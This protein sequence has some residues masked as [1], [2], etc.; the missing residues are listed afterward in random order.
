MSNI[1]LNF[2]FRTL[3][4]TTLGKPQIND[5]THS[6]VITVYTGTSS[7]QTE[8]LKSFTYSSWRPWQN[9]WTNRRVHFSTY[10]QKSYAIPLPIREINTIKNNLH[11]LEVKYREPRL[12]N[13]I[14]TARKWLSRSPDHHDFQIVKDKTNEVLATSYQ[15]LKSMNCFC[16]LMY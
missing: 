11:R 15:K 6:N 3:I 14:A 9:I 8:Y 16:N 5:Y 7:N 1:K 2:H 12:I 10:Q 4:A 13:S